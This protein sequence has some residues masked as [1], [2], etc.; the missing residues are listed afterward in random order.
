MSRFFLG[1]I[2]TASALVFGQIALAADMPV[3]A[4]PPAPPPP[5]WSGFY[6]GADI[7]AGTRSS[8]DVTWV[9]PNFLAGIA[10]AVP[11]PLTLLP[12]GGNGDS[13]GVTGGIYAGYNWQFSPI[14]VFGVEGDINWAHF[15]RQ[16]FLNP[17]VAAVAVTNPTFLSATASNDA[18]ASIRARLGFVG[19]NALWYV[20]GGGAWTEG[21]HTE[22]GTFFNTFSQTGRSDFSKTGWVAGAGA[23][24]MLTPNVLLRAEYLYYRFDG[25]ATAGGPYS[26][27][28]GV[29]SPFATWTGNY[30]IQVARIG[31][32]YKFNWGY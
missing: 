11:S 31:A 25:G 23:E 29:A 19:W 17:S 8:E 20:T 32:S 24:F 30:N 5:S 22:T 16:A 6:L 1:A 2:T 18:L 3:K 13:F 28:F 12:V 4:P 10:G 7:G 15:S 9:D 14:G 27:V 26:P 21:H